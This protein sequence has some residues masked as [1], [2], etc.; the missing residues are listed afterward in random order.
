LIGYD[1]N[2]LSVQLSAISALVLDQ[3][4][5]DTGNPVEAIFVPVSALEG[6]NIVH[7]S[8]SMPWYGGTGSL[9]ELLESLPLIA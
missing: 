2:P 8:S 7:G 9:L 4:A 3:I 6:D 5:E 1:E